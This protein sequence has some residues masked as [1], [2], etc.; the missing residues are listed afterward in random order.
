MIMNKHGYIQA[1]SEI[2]RDEEFYQRE[3]SDKKKEFIAEIKECI[4]ELSNHITDKEARY[5]GDDLVKPRTPLFYGL[6]KIH[7]VFEHLPPMRPIVSGFGSCTTKL[8]EF[9]EHQA[10]RCKSYIKD[11]NQFLLKLQSLKK[12]PS[13]TILVTM[14]VSSLY[15]NIDQEEGAEACFKKLEQ[16]KR[17]NVP[18]L[19]L[20]KL[21]LLV[22]RCN[23]FRFGESFFSQKK[24]TCMGT[25]MA[26]N[27]AN[28]F[29]DDLEEG[30]MKAYFKKT[31]KKPLIWWRYIDDIFFI[32]TD[33]EESLKGF[34]D[35]AQ[36]YS[37]NCNLRSSIRFTVDQSTSEVNFLDV[38]VRLNDGKI[39]TTVYSKP[40]DSHLY[41]NSS[42]NHP[43][44]VVRNIPKSQFMRLRR[45][46]SDAIDFSNQCSRYAKFFLQRRYDPEK[47]QTTIR[48]VS[49]MSRE[50][51]LNPSRLKDNKDR[52]VFVCNWHPRLSSLP[53]VLKDHYYLLR[54]NRQVCNIFKELPL[55]AFRKAKSIRDEVVR[56]D[57]S[58]PSKPECGTKPCQSCKSTCHL[59]CEETKI[60]NAKNGKSVDLKA[61]GNCKT[62]DVVYVARCKVCD[63]LYVGETKEELRIR[64]SK[65]RYDAKKRPENCEL[66]AHVHENNH[67]F[68]K[69]IE[70]TILQQ[71]FKS[72]AE[73][74]FVEDKYI[75][76]LGTAIPN[77]LNKE[78]ES[79]AREMY[80]LHQDL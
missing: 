34:L 36:N 2:L 76:K 69:D 66:A 57:V 22:L 65:H 78:L 30:M 72:E 33:G 5:L 48:K 44:H 40:T 41:L 31:G 71:G 49:K 58:P 20:K 63:I 61:S 6:P 59:I 12:L 18:S 21:I 24:G 29:M 4:D 51:L 75:C 16:R 17:K 56:T 14:D 35:H 74:K 79:Y 70:V 68:E 32:W 67:D 60:V 39:N 46:C 55:V 38:T 45:I 50:D 7:K 26:P 64:F 53:K 42:S 15:T 11:T 77:G 3:E 19:L 52:V 43:R 54:N 25:P 10:Q 27:Y 8:S 13:N 47:T 80:D 37:K 9:L 1:C 62:S 28:L 73:R 23:V